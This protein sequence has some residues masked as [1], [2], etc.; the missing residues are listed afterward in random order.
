MTTWIVATEAN[1]AQ[2]IQTAGKDSKLIVVGNEELYN[3]LNSARVAEIVF[4]SVTGVI[5][6]AAS[7]IAKYLATQ[8]VTTVVGANTLVNRAILTTITSTLKAHWVPNV[9][10]WDPAL[11]QVTKQIAGLARE[12]VALSGVNVF[13]L[14]VD[15]QDYLI[16]SAN[17]PAPSQTITITDEL[18]V[19]L[20]ATNPINDTHTDIAKANKVVGVGRGIAQE[21]DLVLATQLAQVLE[22]KVG[23]TRPL[24]EGHGWFN[25]YI[26]LTG[27]QIAPE[28]YVAIGISGQLHH[29]GGIRG[30]E[31]IVAINEDPQAPIFAE[32]DYGIVGDLYEVVP[33]FTQALMAVK[34]NG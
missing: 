5:E 12:V 24:A 14:P 11:Q 15:S 20:I 21:S 17:P 25:S 9:V 27:H 2:L 3:A 33:A 26:G 31:V 34:N 7:S 16:D 19:E 23:A 29:T 13:T 28:L 18:G 4:F 22:A 8:T 6:N 10:S 32:A 30:A 1:I